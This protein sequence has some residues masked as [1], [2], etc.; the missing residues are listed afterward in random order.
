[1]LIIL[2]FYYLP[3]NLR[4]FTKLWQIQNMANVSKVL[5]KIKLKIYSRTNV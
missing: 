5:K 1:M 3:D 2:A 4:D